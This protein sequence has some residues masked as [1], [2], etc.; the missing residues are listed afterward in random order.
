MILKNGDSLKVAL[1]EAI[2]E[3]SGGDFSEA[4]KSSKKNL[5][6]GSRQ[7]DFTYG[8]FQFD[9][10]IPTHQLMNNLMKLGIDEASAMSMIGEAVA[11]IGKK[12]G[13]NGSELDVNSPPF[14]RFI[15]EQDNAGI[16]NLIDQEFKQFDPKVKITSDDLIDILS[17]SNR[18]LH[19]SMTPS[20]EASE[21]RAPN[22]IINTLIK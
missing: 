10:V 8:R 17:K 20:V 16:K 22:S 3:K 12:A 14:V 13:L 4:I 21:F 15:S 2:E 1:K 6:P 11:K 5:P 18:Q 7:L 19:N 9:H